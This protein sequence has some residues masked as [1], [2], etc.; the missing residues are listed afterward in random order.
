MKI[1]TSIYLSN[2]WYARIK[3]LADRIY[4]LPNE[5]SRFK[6]MEGLRAYAALLVFMVHYFDAYIRSVYGQDP[7]ILQL[8]QIESPGL[9]LSQYLF[10]SHYGVD[11]F[12]LLSGFLVCR[13][14]NR[15]DFRF[16]LFMTNRVRRIY[17]AAI[18]AL[19]IWAYT[20]IVVQGWYGFEL[21]Q[22]IGNLLFLN[23]VP[24]LDVT[25]Y[26]TITWSLFYELLFYMTFPLILLL[27]FGQ[28]RI[29]PV[30]VLLFAAAYMS[31]IQ[32]LGG[33]YI[34]F[35]M[36]FGGALMSTLPVTTLRGLAE[37]IPTWLVL[38]A[39]ITSSFVF[40]EFLMYNYFIPL[41]AVTAFF[42]VL[43]VLYSKGWLYHIF[44]LAPLRYIGNMSFSF[45]LLH[46]LA[47][48]IVMHAWHNIFQTLDGPLY[49]LVTITVCLLLAL[50]LSTVLFLVAERPYFGHKLRG[51][52][53]PPIVAR[54]TAR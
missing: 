53:Q 5:S 7:N 29:K 49:F 19:L 18:I 11:I 37:R 22:F 41:F 2:C 25:P 39:Y 12:F 20:R 23:A 52:A 46:G 26:A 35:L 40:A 27:S 30:H 1:A 13:M 36:F 15:K 48:E 45:Y 32:L 8:S 16:G 38:A 33:M 31:V 6:S 21:P 9:F 4:S 43:K 24:A 54:Q 51:M 14:V 10:A 28:A 34:R 47:I 3:S 42:F 50:A 17:P 44:A